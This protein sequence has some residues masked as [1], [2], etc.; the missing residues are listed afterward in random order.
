MR[1]THPTLLLRM[2]TADPGKRAV[3]DD[4]KEKA[5]QRLYAA[6]RCC[7]QNRVSVAAVYCRV[8]T[9]EQAEGGVSLEMQEAACREWC[10]TNGYTVEV[11]V[12]AGVSGRRFDRP[13][14]QELLGQLAHLDAL[15]V[16]KVDRLAR[17][18][19]DRGL[20]LRECDKRAVRFVAVTQPEI[21]GDS[22]ESQLVGNIVGAVAQFESQMIGA[23]VRAAQRLRREAG[24]LPPKIPY[25]YDDDWQPIGAAAAVIGEIDDLYLGGWGTGR[26]AAHL[27]EVGT[28]SPNGGKWWTG[29]VRQ[30]LRRSIYSGT[31]TW[32]LRRSVPGGSDRLSDEPPIQVEVDVH[33]LRSPETYARIMDQM[34]RRGG[35]Q[36]AKGG[37]PKHPFSSVLHHSPCG[38]A[39]VAKWW[40]RKSDGARRVM[41]YCNGNRSGQCPSNGKVYEDDIIGALHARVQ[42]LVSGEE[43][44]ISTAAPD[45][46]ALHA[47]LE[48]V[49]RSR[50]RI[51][52]AYAAGAVTLDELARHRK[53]ADRREAIILDQLDTPDAGPRR[54]AVADIADRLLAPDN[55]DML[56]GWVLD[57]IERLDWDGQQLA[58]HWRF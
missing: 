37:R 40:T 29:V 15:V 35:L 1:L 51:V 32:G 17:D 24:Q 47:E 55:H 19:V 49:R 57:V 36:N 33:R 28:L 22:P 38:F 14:L 30:T 26:I 56:R 20:I 16:W 31:L 23:R 2:P 34:D 18:N 58:V 9:R 41:Y 21:G 8:S 48:S 44:T 5:A 53:T 10:E 12:D 46:A 3:W 42:D 43:V 50:Q 4:S 54:V 39:M 45:V 7:R 6:A 27:N 25:G 52:D 13:A 11:F